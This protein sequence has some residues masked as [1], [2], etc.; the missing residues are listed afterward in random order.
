[1]SNIKLSTRKPDV[2]D[3]WENL[4]H[5]RYK[6]YKEGKLQDFKTLNE[7]LK[8]IRQSNG[9]TDAEI[10][11]E[12]AV[13]DEKLNEPF[14]LPFDNPNIKYD[15]FDKEGKPMGLSLNIAQLSD[16]NNRH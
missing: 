13:Y 9:W 11:E 16:L 8:I 6:A 2:L 14:G 7:Q 4:C 10:Q 5:Q 12:F 1:M 15:V 3:I